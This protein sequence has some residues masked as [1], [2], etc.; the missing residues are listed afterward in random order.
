MSFERIAK[1]DVQQP[2]TF[3]RGLCLGSIALIAAV[4][5]AGPASAGLLGGGLSVGVG[6]GVGGTG[7]GAEVGVGG[8]SGGASVGVGIGTGTGGGLGVGVDIGLG[9]GTG[10]GTGGGVPGEG[11][12][13]ARPDFN[14]AG[15]L[16]CAK[17]GNEASYNG[18]VVRDKS[19]DPIG[20]VNDATLSADNRLMSIRFQG[21][22]NSCFKLSGAGLRVAKGEVW[23]NVDGSGLR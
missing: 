14:F 23:A 9:G 11:P 1:V 17:G 8:S 3:S 6:V 7:V 19:G 21:A 2:G 15:S 10:G 18:F 13:L 16:P 12:T 5:A 22:G 4:L 20:W